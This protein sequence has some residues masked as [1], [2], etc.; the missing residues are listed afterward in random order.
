ML[1]DENYTMIGKY[2]GK[3]YIDV[4]KGTFKFMYSAVKT[5]GYTT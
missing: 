5:N 2:Q 4:N 1:I 3:E